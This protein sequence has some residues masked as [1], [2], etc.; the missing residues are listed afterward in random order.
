[1]PNPVEDDRRDDVRRLFRHRYPDGAGVS[2]VL[3]FHAWL[4][5][6]RPDLLPTGP[7]RYD[8]LRLDLE[9][10]YIK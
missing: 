10:L 6:T 7:R 2:E 4:E 8:D 5:R 9:G 1:M 3:A